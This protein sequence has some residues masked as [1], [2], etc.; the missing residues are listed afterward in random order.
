MS[1]GEQD[2]P[3]NSPV[4]DTPDDTGT[5]TIHFCLGDRLWIWRQETN[6][7]ERP[8]RMTLAITITPIGSIDFSIYSIMVIITLYSQRDEYT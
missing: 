5:K 6:R 8:G 7:P 3:G 1:P 4:K 2:G